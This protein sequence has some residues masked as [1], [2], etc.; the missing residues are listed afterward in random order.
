MAA[1]ELTLYE[2]IVWN[3]VFELHLK[4]LDSVILQK[5]QSLLKQ[6]FK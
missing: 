2:V 6:S 3:F 4:H 1:F 5:Y